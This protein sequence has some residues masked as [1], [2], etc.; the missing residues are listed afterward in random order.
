MA[1]DPASIDADIAV[2][3]SGPGG[4]TA[5]FRAAD[6]GKKVVLIE[7]Y[8]TLGGVCLNVG[9]IPSKAFL[10]A[11]KVLSEAN[12]IKECGIDFGKPNIDTEKLRKWVMKVISQ[13][14][15]GLAGL[16][17]KRGVQVVSGYGQFTSA[18]QINVVHDDTVTRVNFS[19][20]IIAAGSQAAKLPFI[21][22]DPR[23]LDS[24]SALE[25]KRIPKRMLVVGGGIIG[26]E[27][28][29]VYHELGT[30]V[31]IVEVLDRLVSEADPDLVKPLESRISSKYERI[32][33]GTRVTSVDCESDML[34]VQFEKNGEKFADQFDNILVA[35]GRQ[36]NGAKI[37][38]ENASVRVS[39]DGFIAVDR[40]MRT[41]IANI[42]AIGD[43]VGQPMLA[44]KAVH[45]GKV[46]AEVAAGL[47][48]GFDTDIIP[49]VAYT[50]PEIAWAGLTENEAK[51]E[52]IE[53]E[54]ASFPWAASGRAL[55]TNRSEG[56]TKLLFEPTTNRVIGA[57][58]TGPNA[59]ELIAE[60]MLAIEMGADAQDLAL[61]I[62]P[63]PTLS[64]TIGFAAE[65]QEGTITDLYMP[66]RKPRRK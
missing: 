31:T 25:L 14:T 55:S 61:T 12:E 59:G 66:K 5:A 29:T 54:K 44:H 10:H 41:N 24:T 43:I 60:A 49:S 56:L 15:G 11:A 20:A 37:G 26:L 30:S 13:L 2:L 63:H 28:A 33:H 3:G 57:G 34:S 50:D 4:Y 62:H 39:D 8:P 46:A 53:Y 19:Q 16:A 36:P 23:V 9:C 58:M 40:Q 17:H 42:F 6:L 51:R 52:G 27:L 21:P 35:V 1:Q 45:Q 48:A 22:E 65:M 18:H 47:K 38:V 64:E 32:M 7:R